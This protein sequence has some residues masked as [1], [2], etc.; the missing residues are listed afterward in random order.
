MKLLKS[1]IVMSYRTPQKC[2]KVLHLI[3]GCLASKDNHESWRMC[4]TSAEY[5]TVITAV[6]TV[7]SGMNPHTI[8]ITWVGMV[9]KSGVGQS[10][11]LG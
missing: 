7:M 8:R 1:L 4:T 6:L 11:T 9:E 2:V 3:N 10:C 5:R